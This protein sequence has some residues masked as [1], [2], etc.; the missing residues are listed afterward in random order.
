MK[1]A[2]RIPHSALFLALL[3]CAGLA[4]ADWLTHRGNPERTGSLDDQ[5]GP[6]A[7]KVLWTFKAQQ[8][9]IASPVAEGNLLFVSGLGAFNT[10]VFHALLTDPRAEQRIFWSKSAPF[11]KLP[12]VC[13]PAVA[14]SLIVFGDGMHQTD[15]AILYAVKADTGRLAWQFPVPGKLIHIEGA[16]T[17]DKGRVFI[18]GGEAGV[19][20][21]ALKQITLDGQ[22]TDFAAA[23]EAVTKRWAELTAKYEEEKKK[24]P[25]ALPPTED[26]LPKRAPKLLWRQGE[27][28]WHVDA[29]VAVAND[30]VLVASAYID[31]EKIGKRVLLCLNAADGNPLWEVP[32]T[33]NPWGGPTVAGNLVF[34]GCSSIRYDKK[35]IPGAKGEVVALDLANG[36]VKWRRETPGGVLSSVAVKGDLAIFTCTDGRIRAWNIN[37]GEQKWEFLAPN[38]FFGGVAVA[39]GVVYAADLKCVLYAVNL[40]DGKLVFTLDV[41]ADPAVQAPGMVFGSPTVHAGDLYLATCNLEGTSATQVPCAVVCVS[42]RAGTAAAAAAF[43]V[44]KKRRRIEIPCKIAARKLPNL[45]E[46]YPLEVVATYPPP[47]GQKAHE[48]VVTFDVRPSDVHK[49]LEKFGLKPGTPARGDEEPA[50]GPEINVYLAVPGILEGKPRL[51]PMYRTMVDRRTGKTL[52]PLKWFFTGSAMRQPDPDKPYKTYGADLGGTL[53]TLFPVTDETVFQTNLT[54][55][56]STLLKMEINR[57]VLPDEGTPVTLIIEVP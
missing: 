42:D 9:F 38:P 17:I 34:I 41:A 33:V 19:I 26:S 48:T 13:S 28:K 35:L 46:I 10:G 53:I 40:A 12:M 44:D 37:T 43:S 36:Q 5:P 11:L 49:A 30:R 4:Q 23:Q 18:G 7:G 1:S 50:T 21:V 52:P 3:V 51:L 16:P 32:L 2:L 14:E 54:M 39:G 55:K 15:G 57:Y 29:P 45:Q 31:E 6:K 47:Q 25:L 8:H 20:A 27:G 24:D 22:D 56:D